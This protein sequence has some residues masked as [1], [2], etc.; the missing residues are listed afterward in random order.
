[1]RFRFK[2]LPASEFEALFGLSDAELAARDIRRVTADEKPG[3]PCRVT[4]E[5]AEPGET[6]LLL[7]YKHLPAHSPYQSSGPIFVREGA[8]E[9]YD[10]A[11]LPPVFRGRTLSVRAYDKADMMVEADI[12]QGDEAEAALARMLDRGDV[13]YLHVHNAKRGCYAAR[14][15]RAA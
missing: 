10:G 12:V 8:R 6:L 1:M 14:V 11:G 3:F 5:D 9:T 4:L 15:E 2:G 7:S 13:A